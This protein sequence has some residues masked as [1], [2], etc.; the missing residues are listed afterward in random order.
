[1]NLNNEKETLSFRGNKGVN[2]AANALFNN[3]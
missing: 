3:F 2:V 1:M